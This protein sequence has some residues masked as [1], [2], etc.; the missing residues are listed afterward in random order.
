[1]TTFAD[2]LYSSITSSKSFLVA[3]CDPVLDALPD[4]LISQAANHKP[5]A[6][7][8]ECISYALDS[9]CDIMLTAVAGNVAAIK[10][11]IAFFE[12]YGLVGLTSFARFCRAIR[13][14]GVP[15]IADA[16]RGDIGSTASAYS[17]AFLGE[18]GFP[19]RSATTGDLICDAV[20][21]NPFLGF[22]TLEPFL[23]EC[24]AHGRGMFVL[25]QTSNPGAAALQGLECG[26]GTVSEH[27]ARWVARHANE[28]LGE[29]GFSGLGAVVGAVYPQQAVRLR[30]I[31][32][33]SFF[34]IPGL[35]AQGGSASDAIAG[36]SKLNGDLG[37]GVINV[38]RGLLEGARGADSAEGLIGVIRGNVE[39]FNRAVA[40]ALGG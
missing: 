9:F 4:L 12:Q 10:P 33:S 19:G 36:F 34:L 23:N 1:M 32:P 7:D 39:R 27:V 37:G 31:M 15:L 28:L 38:S 17:A 3:G 5:G 2:R 14:K 8:A 40:A 30:E 20:T 6:S 11:N 16:K 22:D 24:K 25:V 26:A 18:R 29:C 13:A 21:V 35:G